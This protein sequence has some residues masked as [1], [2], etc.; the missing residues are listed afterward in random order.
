MDIGLG[1]YG[2]GFHAIIHCEP[3]IRDPDGGL[4]NSKLILCSIPLLIPIVMAQNAATGGFCPM[5]NEALRKFET[6][7][8]LERPEFSNLMRNERHWC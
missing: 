3:L 2:L 6:I 4:Q 1:L 5:E 8:L 7:K